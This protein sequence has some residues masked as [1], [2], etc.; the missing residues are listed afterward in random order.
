M[1]TLYGKHNPMMLNDVY[2]YNAIT[3]I[4]LKNLDQRL[5]QHK[6]FTK[7]MGYHEVDMASNNFFCLFSSA[8]VQELLTTSKTVNF[9]VFFLVAS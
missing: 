9:Y 2:M 6:S 8:N 4:C 7:V 1:Y 3:D 5:Q